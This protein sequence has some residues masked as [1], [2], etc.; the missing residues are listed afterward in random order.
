MGGAAMEGFFSNRGVAAMFARVFSADMPKERREGDKIAKLLQEQ[1]LPRVAKEN[2]FRGVTFF[3]DRH[4]GKLMSVT[5]YDNEAQMKQA[6]D[7][8]KEFRAG[9]LKQLGGSHLTAESF[10]VVASRAP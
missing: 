6:H 4:S 10:E 1:V 5:L 8:I 2:G 3:F 9:I 7:D